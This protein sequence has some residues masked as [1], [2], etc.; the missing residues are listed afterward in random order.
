M[1]SNIIMPPNFQKTPQQKNNFS[2]QTSQLSLNRTNSSSQAIMSDYHQYRKTIQSSVFNYYVR[3]LRQQ[4]PDWPDSHPGRVINLSDPWNQKP[5]D[6]TTG[7]SPWVIPLFANKTSMNQYVYIYQQF[8]A[9]ATRT[10]QT[11]LNS[12]NQQLPKQLPI[13][14]FNFQFQSSQE[15]QMYQNQLLNE[16]V[17][18]RKKLALYV[19]PELWWLIP[20]AFH[21]VEWG[22]RRSPRIDNRDHMLYSL[23]QVVPTAETSDIDWAGTSELGSKSLANVSIPLLTIYTMLTD[24]Y[25]GWASLS[26]VLTNLLN[27]E[28]SN[29]STA[30]SNEINNSET[31]LYEKRKKKFFVHPSQ[32]FSSGSSRVGIDDF[33]INPEGAARAD[34]MMTAMDVAVQAGRISWQETEDSVERWEALVKTMDQ[35]HML[36]VFRLF[37]TRSR[38]PLPGVMFVP[39]SQRKLNQLSW[40]INPIDNNN[41]NGLK[42]QQT[43]NQHSEKSDNQNDKYWISINKTRHITYEEVEILI[44][45]MLLKL[46]V[47]WT[48]RYISPLD[49]LI[50]WIEPSDIEKRATEFMELTQ[51]YEKKLNMKKSSTNNE[52]GEEE[53]DNNA[54]KN[55]L[56]NIDEDYYHTWALYDIVLSIAYRLSRTELIFIEMAALCQ[57]ELL[58]KMMNQEILNSE[59]SVD[60]KQTGHVNTLDAK[61]LM[62]TQVPGKKD[63]KR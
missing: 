51:N 37:T 8:I 4:V 3:E 52:M 44:F 48:C 20:A 50:S 31:T 23:A 38:G 62:E 18:M 30:Q 9:H 1:Q 46:D 60:E 49:V 2:S 13:A 56:N 57:E 19:S 43:Q 58:K 59:T 26:H 35:L 27:H 21:T 28:R 42:K 34:H 61:Y 53:E 17:K 47:S 24:R 63:L 15:V 55:N 41:N 54:E 22:L 32:R 40:M 11:Q 12:Q 29:K 16:A 45:H 33:F 39:Y 7:S 5:V 25:R 36:S 6:T 14:Q 10:L